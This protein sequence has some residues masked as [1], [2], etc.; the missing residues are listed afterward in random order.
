MW[1]TKSVKSLDVPLP[2]AWQDSPRQWLPRYTVRNMVE[3]DK[4]D[5]ELVSCLHFPEKFFY[6]LTKIFSTF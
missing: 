1:N 3:L 4:N 6:F 2:W 5:W